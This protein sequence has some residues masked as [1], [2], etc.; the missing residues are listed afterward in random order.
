MKEPTYYGVLPAAIRYDET[1]SMS[2]KVLFTEFTALCNRSGICTAHNRY[3]ADLYGVELKTVSVW[4]QHIK[5]KGY[6]DVIVSKE[7]GNKREIKLTTDIIKDTSPEKTGEPSPLISGDLYNNT[8]INNKYHKNDIAGSL[9]KYYYGKYITRCKRKP[10]VSGGWITNL[11]SLLRNSSE[12][13]VTRVI[14]YFF[15]YEGRVDFSFY[16]FIKKFDALAPKALS[17]LEVKKELR[18]W[19][20]KHC[21]HVNFNT[22]PAC[23]KCTEERWKPEST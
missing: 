4:I 13:E 22:L 1:L 20:C 6:I 19:T 10:R 9:L 16:T 17:T 15:A 3:F 21:G 8:S 7:K 12:E 5:E 23:V 11:S 2:E 18:G 14:D